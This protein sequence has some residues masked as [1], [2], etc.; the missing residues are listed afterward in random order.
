MLFR[1]LFDAASS[2]YTYLLADEV[3]RDA[4]LIDSVFE[5][6]P[7]DRALLRELRL[8]LRYT[9]ETHVHADHV[10]AA[11]RF[12]DALGSRIV[13][14]KHS[15]AQGADVYVDDGDTISI[16]AIVLAARATPGHTNGCTTWVTEDPTGR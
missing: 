16:G 4:L 7:R 9:I 3:S 10:T 13:V 5:Q 15:G 14:S 1:Q 8:A 11:W 2:T 6:F 12:R